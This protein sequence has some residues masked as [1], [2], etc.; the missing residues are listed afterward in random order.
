M[1]E[2]EAQVQHCGPDDCVILQVD[3][4]DKSGTAVIDDY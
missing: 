1:E 4:D 2:Q 3:A